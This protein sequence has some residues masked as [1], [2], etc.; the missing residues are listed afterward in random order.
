MIMNSFKEIGGYLGLEVQKTNNILSNG[1]VIALN[2]ART[3]FQY[4][5][6]AFNI[7]EICLPYYTCPVIWQAAQ[8]ENCKIKFYHIDNNFMPNI[9]FNKEDYILYTN[10]FGVCA[11]NVKKLAKKYKNLIVDNAQAFYMPKY[12]IA[13]FNS[14]RKFF[15]V[16]DGSIL[17]CDEKLNK[18]FETDKSYMR[19]AYLLKRI[20]VN[21]DYG[22]EDF[23]NN[24]KYFNDEPIKY[25][26]N[27]TSS[28]VCCLDINNAKRIRLK[29]FKTLHNKLRETNELKLELTKDDVPM[30][31]PYLIEDDKLRKKLIKHKIYVATYWNPLP[32]EYSEGYFQKYLLPLPID[33]RY[34][35]EDMK[36]I[37]ECINEKN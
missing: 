14:I 36:F 11:N 19:C 34:S 18:H 33:Q 3:A 8:K 31:Y 28:L 6:K 4:V 20:D 5:I 32:K 16:P 35:I 13:S 10:Y 12:G 2:L 15:G 22:Y 1:N 9:E 25:M 24:E 7:K 27:L 26:S 21:A 37:M 17:K 23:H 29:N 30:V